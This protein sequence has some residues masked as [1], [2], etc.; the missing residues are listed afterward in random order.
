MV[1]FENLNYRDILIRFRQL[2]PMQQAAIVGVIFLVVYLP[3]SYFLLH[4]TP[5]ESFRMSVFSTIIFVVVY[6]FTSVIF[7]KKGVQASQARS[8][9]PRKGLRNK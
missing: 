6:Y 7:V 5:A 8:R 4:M 3:Y 2:M 1:S 9:G